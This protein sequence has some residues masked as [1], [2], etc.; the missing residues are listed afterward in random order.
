MRK[1]TKKELKI[2]KQPKKPLCLNRTGAPLSSRCTLQDMANFASQCTDNGIDPN[3][4]L[5]AGCDCYEVNC[6][7][8]SEYEESKRK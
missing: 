1:I 5:V 6:E 4:I 3:T 8:M 7:R 2:L